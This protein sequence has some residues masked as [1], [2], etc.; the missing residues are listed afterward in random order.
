MRDCRCSEDTQFLPRNSPGGSG[1]GS[2]LLEVEGTVGG[3]DDC[4]AEAWRLFP[5]SDRGSP[6]GKVLLEDSVEAAFVPD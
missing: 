2:P 4:L 5:S 3:A 6:A 1:D